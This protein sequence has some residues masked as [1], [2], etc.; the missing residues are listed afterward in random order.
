MGWRAMLDTAMDLVLP[1]TC[2]GCHAPV[3]WCGACAA[4]LRRRPRAATLSET[5]LDLAADRDLVLPPVHALTRYAGPVRAA[6]IAGKER[7]R[8][9]LPPLVGAALGAGLRTLQDLAVH[10][11]EVWLVPAP[12]RPAAARARGD[13]PVLAMAR[14]AARHLAERGRRAGVAPCLTVGRGARDSV[15]LDARARLANLI[16]RVRFRPA[17]APPAP[18]AVILVDDVLTSGSTVIASLLALREQGVSTAG[19]LTVAAAAQLRAE[20][21]SL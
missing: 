9:D 18:S 1:R 12:T 13:D 2:P 11:S 6:I 21:L 3:P 5:A 10:P 15:G 20:H 19:V 14:A 16:G 4:T 17:G 7:G 8:R